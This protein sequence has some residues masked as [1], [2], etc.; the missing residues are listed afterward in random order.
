MPSFSIITVTFNS[1]RYLKEAMESV[2]SQDGVDLEYILV[3]GGSTDATLELIRCQAAADSR[4][5]W[6]SGPDEGIADAFN[7]GLALAT[8]EIIGI[9]NSDDIYC[10]GTLR[11]VAET[12][13]TDPK[14][15]V[16]HGD[17]IRFTDDRPLF[18]LKPA[19][20][21]RCIW[22]EMPLNHPATF[23]KRRAYEQIGTFDKNLRL[24][25]DYDLVLR[26][27]LNRCR[28]CYLERVL[29]KMR[30]GGKSDARFWGARKE[31]FAISVRH[32]YPVYR[33]F[34]WL[35]VKTA[36]NLGKNFLR[37]MGLYGLLRLHPRFRGDGM[38]PS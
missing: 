13:R 24:A 18:R 16:V 31:V 12:W 3:D 7:K 15:D 34:C 25:M 2:L 14:C 10:A 29:V 9:L 1:A 6:L 4:V 38:R 30:Y 27:Y 11:A 8:G 5:K 37:R 17:L 32:G 35:M 33:A 21:E 23:V 28:F 19:D 20:I 26:L 36:M 22:H